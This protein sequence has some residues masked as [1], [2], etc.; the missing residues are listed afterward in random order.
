M[1]SWGNMQV[2]S[3]RIICS[4]VLMSSHFFQQKCIGFICYRKHLLGNETQD[5]TKS[6]THPTTVTNFISLPPPCNHI[7]PGIQAIFPFFWSLFLFLTQISDFFFCR[8]KNCWEEGTNQLTKTATCCPCS[9]FS[10]LLN[11]GKLLFEKCYAMLC[12]RASSA[13]QG[14]LDK[15]GKGLSELYTHLYLFFSLKEGGKKKKDT[16]L[17]LINALNC[18]CFFSF[19]VKK[20]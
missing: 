10:S 6:Q 18:L 5:S 2:E 15:L 11:T 16:L 7:F 3:H 12:Y 9:L 19:E 14:S 1:L 4:C 20:W 17:Y 8:G 13:M